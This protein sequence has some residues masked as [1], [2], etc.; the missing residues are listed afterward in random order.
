MKK[1][2]TLPITTFLINLFVFCIFINSSTSAQ[3][4]NWLWAKSAGG[5]NGS[6]YGNSI[7]TDAYGN[8]YVTGYFNSFTIAF[9]SYILNN[10]N[11]TYPLIDNIFL[12]KYDA[13]GN[14]LWAKSFGGTGTG[15][16]GAYGDKGQSI[17]IDASGN[18]YI[19]GEFSSPSITFGNYTL[20]NYGNNAYDV[21]IAK[22]DA[23]GNA[24]WAK[25]AGGNYYD[26]SY[27]IK[28]DASGNV[29]ITGEFDSPSITFGNYTLNNHGNNAYDVFFAKFDVNGNVLWAKSAGGNADDVGNSITTDAS[30]N[31]Y[32]T[33]EFDPPSITFGNYTLNNT[34]VWDI[35]LVKYNASGNV[36]WAKSAIG[37]NNDYAN[38]VT[39]DA[40]GNAYVA[41]Q[42]DSPTMTVGSI[43][44]TNANTNGSFDL[45][46]AKYDTGGN[47]LWAKSAGG[48]DYDVAYSVAVDVSGN[49]YVV[50]C[51]NSSTLTFGSTTLT[52]AGYENI[53]LV[54]YDA[55]GNVLWAKS[56]GGTGSDGANSVAV[57]ASGNTYLTGYFLSSTITFGS[58]TLT[59][60]Y[61]GLFD[62][63]LAKLG[64]GTGI[65]EFSNKFDISVFPNPSIDNITI[66]I[67]QKATIEISN[68]QGQLIK[69]LAV[70][71]NKTSIDV[72]AFPC[73]MYVVKVKTEKGVAVKK[74]VKE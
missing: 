1:L 9:G 37:T 2:F 50:G 74:F 66:I 4:P 41:G 33:G 24:L 15:N 13:N 22:F 57:D 53:F 72:S 36:L 21:F 48:T 31:V 38:S 61:V 69:T 34:G 7:I 27:S 30:G 65:N 6:S 16:N 25:S 55:G 18:I 51:F 42:F 62:I 12:A 52:N 54:K 47:V 58:T 64:N 8:S 71:S 28:A 29:Y 11:S 40:L 68:I 60:A 5:N 23:G 14:V 43:T 59:N 70:S 19:T 49:A 39:V 73:G 10:A 20:N 3:A 35:F 45:F 26:M 46:L 17:T 67:P 63:F 56:A 44:L 32:I